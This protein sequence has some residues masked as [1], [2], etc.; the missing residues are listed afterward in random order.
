[1]FGKVVYARPARFISKTADLNS[2][3]YGVAVYTKFPKVNSVLVCIGQIFNE[4]GKK[5]LFMIIDS[6]CSFQTITVFA[7]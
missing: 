7:T 3:K 4:M 6:D 5:K 1:M 2:M